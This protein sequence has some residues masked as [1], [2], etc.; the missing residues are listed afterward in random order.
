LDTFTPVLA[1]YRVYNDDGGEA[2]STPVAN[3]DTAASVAAQYGGTTIVHLRVM[4][5]NALA[6]ADVTAGVYQLQ[7]DI[8]GGG[9]AD[10]TG[11]STGVRS[12]D[13]AN[14]T[15][16]AAATN[17]GTNGLTDPALAFQAGVQ[18]EDGVLTW[19]GGA[20]S[21][22][23]LVYA[24]ELVGNDLANG[25]AVTFRL[26]DDGG[27]FTHTFTPTINVTQT[28]PTISS[29]TMADGG[30]SWVNSTQ[31]ITV[32]F[33]E[34][35][36]GAPAVDATIPGL[37]AQLNGG[38]SQALTYQS[39]APG[40]AWVVRAPFLVQN[41]DTVVFDYSMASGVIVA[42]DDAA[43][44]RETTDAAVTNNLTKRVR[45]SLKKADDTVVVSETVKY[46]V[47]QF[48]SGAPANA[49][50]MAREVK[51]ATA[52]DASGEVDV[53]YSAGAAA[54]G[55]TVYVVV[56]RPDTTPTESM[57]WTDVVQ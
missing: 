8:A 10:V 51:G 26:L 32:N 53:D 33:S 12:V 44:L 37:T 1:H 15:N 11:A 7:R 49:N 5:S 3:E 22:T 20:S 27:T 54:V 39:G 28:N 40:A 25:Q 34:S 21:F 41:G 46:S 30:R 57:V 55:G 16:D 52:T 9:F 45:F 2:A 56:I 35:C 24:I 13:S 18:C 4:I 47:H 17:R 43:E 6:A 19:V 36:T 31:D 48:D 29:A 42:V 50:W 38:A 23:E 14:L